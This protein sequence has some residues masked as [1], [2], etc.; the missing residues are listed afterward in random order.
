MRRLATK[1]YGL[2]L[3]CQLNVLAGEF[4]SG[5]PP[6]HLF[7]IAV[8]RRSHPASKDRQIEGHLMKPL[9]TIHSGEYLVGSYIE[10]H[11]KRVNVWVPSRDMGVDLLVSDRHNRRSVSLQVKFSRDFL[12]THM[13]PAFQKPLRACGWWTINRDKLRTSPADFWVFVLPGLA[14]YTTDFVILPPKELLRRLRSIHSP[15][16]MIQSYLWV[17]ERERC[18]ETRG[19]RHEYQLQIADGNYREATRDFTKWLNTWTPVAQLNR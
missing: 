18:W 11:F 6:S 7:D 12:V 14:R 17:T 10:Q 2:F 15:R 5:R 16:K 8:T 4:G 13:G 1:G 9:F 3:C 19:L